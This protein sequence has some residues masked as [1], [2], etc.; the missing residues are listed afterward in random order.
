MSKVSGAEILGELVGRAL[1]DFYVE[2]GALE[3]HF[4]DV[5]IVVYA[6]YDES[7]V[8]VEVREA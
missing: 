7:D 3:L 4:E 2:G 6:D 1:T 5:R 8:W